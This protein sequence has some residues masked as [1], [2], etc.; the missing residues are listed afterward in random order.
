MKRKKEKDYEKNLSTFAR[1]RYDRNN[2]C[3]LRQEER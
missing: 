3:W 2:A 1:F